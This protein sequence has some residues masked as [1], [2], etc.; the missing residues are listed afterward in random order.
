MPLQAL[1]RSEEQRGGSGQA[2]DLRLGRWQDVLSDVEVDAV[3]CDPPYGEATHKA[4]DGRNLSAKDNKKGGGKKYKGWTGERRPIN[5]Q[6]WTPLDV[7]DFVAHWG[8]RCRGWF[9]AMTSHD[10]LAAWREALAADDRYVFAPLPHVAVGSR[11]RLAGDGPSSW[12]EWI[13]VARPRSKKFSRWGTLP[14]AYIVPSG[15]TERG[16]KDVVG[17]KPLWTMR[18]LVRDYSRPGDLVCDPCAGAATTLIAAAI[19]GRSGIGAE[20]DP[21][22][23]AIAEARIAR[24]YTPDLFGAAPPPFKEA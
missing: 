6:H 10:L 24:G 18:S 2:I 21:K 19:E 16:E 11:V 14:G 17:G 1:Q 8:P 15:H 3:I 23:F 9:V 20:V 5:Y 12:T 7:T 22:T 13:I 4:N